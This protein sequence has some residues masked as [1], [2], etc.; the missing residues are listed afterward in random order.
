LIVVAFLI[1]ELP[2]WAGLVGAVVATA[3][4]AFSG[5]IDDNLAV[6]L[7]SGAAMLAIMH[8]SGYE[9]ARLFDALIAA[10]NG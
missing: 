1:P 8:F 10:I 7:A 9:H 4:E 2:L 3:A 6:P 5:R